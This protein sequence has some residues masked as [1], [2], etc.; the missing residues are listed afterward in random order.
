M[1]FALCA[2]RAL[3]YLDW[4]DQQGLTVFGFDMWAMTEQHPYA[5]PRLNERGD[6]FQCRE[7]I[8]SIEAKHAEEMVTRHSVTPAY[9][10]WVRH[11]G[12]ERLDRG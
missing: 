4:C 1:K 3:S 12:D 7:A 6:P 8:R 11:A 9:N 2:E 10:I 5:H